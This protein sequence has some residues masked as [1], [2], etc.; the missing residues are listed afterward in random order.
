MS[1]KGSNLKVREALKVGPMRSHELRVA[2]GLTHNECSSALASQVRGGFIGHDGGERFVRVYHF[3]C[4]P[5][6][7]LTPEQRKANQAAYDKKRRNRVRK[8][9]VA[10]PTKPAKVKPSERIRTINHQ[11]VQTSIARKFVKP[12]PV[13]GPRMSSFDWEALGLGKVERIPA[14]WEVARG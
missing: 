9:R 3:I 8:P 1:R 6:P 5:A 4:D 12:E 13:D 14:V 2:L 11:N 7:K 10:K